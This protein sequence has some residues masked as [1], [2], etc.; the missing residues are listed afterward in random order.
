M[1]T[2][3]RTRISTRHPKT[4]FLSTK[5]SHLPQRDKEQGIR[6]RDSRERM[7]KR[8]GNKGERE[9]VIRSRVGDKGLPQ[10]RRVRSGP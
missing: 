10:D 1:G 5:E 6:N 2:L 8:G 4:K 7:K 3:E 9:R